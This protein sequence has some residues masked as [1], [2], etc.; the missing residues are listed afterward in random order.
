MG[1]TGVRPWVSEPLGVNGSAGARPVD[2]RVND[3]DEIRLGQP[4]RESDPARVRSS[5]GLD[6][7]DF[8]HR[9][10]P[11]GEQGGL[12]SPDQAAAEDDDHVGVG[13]LRVLQGPRARFDLEPVLLEQLG[14]VG[15]A[16]R[17]YEHLRTGT[18]HGGMI[19]RIAPF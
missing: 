11:L 4:V 18:G 12:L 7:Q 5:G 13:L 9:K 10:S 19:P 16:G 8:D 3:L 15:L 17:E 2:R 1:Q 6:G 14:E